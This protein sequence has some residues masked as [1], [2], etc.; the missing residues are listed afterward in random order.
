MKK[1]VLK[2]ITYLIPLSLLLSIHAQAEEHKRFSVSAGWLHVMPQ[3]SANPIN[4][5]TQVKNG[6]NYGVGEISP[7]SFMNSIPADTKV[8]GTDP[9]FLTRDYLKQLFAIQ[10]GQTTSDAQNLEVQGPGKDG[11]ILPHATGTTSIY[12]IEQWR[13]KGTGLEAEKVDT[14]GLTLNYY[15]TDQV[16]LQFIGGIPP[17]VDIKGKGKI[18][19]KVTGRA[20][21]PDVMVAAVAGPDG[22]PIKTDVEITNLGN[23]GKVSTARAWTPAFLAQYQFGR[24]GVNKFRPYIG[25]GIMY[26]HFN[27]IKLNSQTHNDLVA[28]GHMVQNIL[29]NKAGSALD[30]RPSSAKPQVKV[31]ADDALAPIVS[32][33]F[34]YDINPE[35]YAVASVSYAKLNNQVKIKVNNANNKGSELL[36][37]NTKVEVD[38]IMTYLG[39]GYRF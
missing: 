6:G 18:I 9:Y 36:S 31:R 23:K 30:G 11:Y 5:H 27:Q 29:D 4:I 15:L 1:N 7:T 22:F 8:G 14:L 17:K 10:P 24:T 34:T 13:E 21:S 37:S 3:G 39:V 12:G 20:I 38:P 2:A 16:S 19:A 32:L 25:G 35:W 28:A 33:G 26:A